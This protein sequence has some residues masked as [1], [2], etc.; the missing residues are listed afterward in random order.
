V[1]RY[2]AAIIAIDGARVCSLMYSLAAESL[3]EV[4]G[5]VPG[6]PARHGGACAVITSELLKRQHRRLADD[7]KRFHV[8]GVR[9]LGNQGIA[10]LGTGTRATRALPLQR[11]YGVWKID[12]ASATLIL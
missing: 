9:I 12:G 11:E 2:D 10:L 7:A 3:E 6:P 4:H 1:K 5:A 8:V